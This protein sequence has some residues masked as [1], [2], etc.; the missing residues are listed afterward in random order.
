MTA[1]EKLVELVRC[2]LLE[3]VKKSLMEK[4]PEASESDIDDMIARYE[5]FNPPPV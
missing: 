4:Y 3:N 5:E 1:A 2:L